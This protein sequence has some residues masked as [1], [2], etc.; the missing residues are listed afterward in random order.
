MR[1]CTKTLGSDE[2]FC[3]VAVQ[4]SSRPRRARSP[5]WNFRRQNL[6]CRKSVS[7]M[8]GEFCCSVCYTRSSAFYGRIGKRTPRSP[9][10]HGPSLASATQIARIEM[11]P[12][13]ARSRQCILDRRA[14]SS[15]GSVVNI[16]SGT[17]AAS[18]FEGDTC[19]AAYA[20]VSAAAESGDSVGS[21]RYE[22]CRS[23]PARVEFAGKNRPFSHPLSILSM[24]FFIKAASH[25]RYWAQLMSPSC[26]VP[27]LWIN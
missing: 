24:Q 19:V 12:A 15:V 20:A 26:R 22:A 6:V 17:L 21:L 10:Q 25:F 1:N 13:N 14:R 3:A 16:A 23:G 9:R 4:P 27:A 5:R 11:P 18:S 2:L 8:K 7:E